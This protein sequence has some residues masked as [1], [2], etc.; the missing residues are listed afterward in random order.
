MHLYAPQCTFHLSSPHAANSRVKYVAAM[1]NE[2]LLME[3]EEA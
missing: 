3:Y 2:I 1:L